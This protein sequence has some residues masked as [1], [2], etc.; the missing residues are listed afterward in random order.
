MARYTSI[1]HRFWVMFSLWVAAI[2]V[3]TALGVYAAAN[4]S[5][6]A[7]ARQELDR[8]SIYYGQQ[9][10]RNPQTPLPDTWLLRG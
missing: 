7:I 6:T 10:V 3:V 5:R 4:S 9:L 8:E 2:S 1:G